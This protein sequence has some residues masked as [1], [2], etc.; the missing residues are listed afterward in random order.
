M[1]A[2]LGRVLA[3]GLPIALLAGPLAAQEPAPVWANLNSGVYHCPG[4]Q[5]YGRTVRGEF[6]D[7]SIARERGFRP[8]GG[9]PCTPGLPAA[10]S[11]LAGPAPDAPD[12]TPPR[13]ESG[14]VECA[15]TRIT[16]GDTIWCGALGEIRLIGMDTPESDQE[17]YGTAA[18]AALAALAPVATVLQV[19]V[20]ADPRDRYGRLLAY[21]WLDGVMLNWLLV[22]QGWAVSL[23]YEPN[24]RYR[25]AFE[26]AEWRAAA[27]ARGLW[28]VGGLLC[29]PVDHRRGSC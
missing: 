20:G 24:T 8:N 21:A 5:H 7:E 22:R 12:T 1:R 13:P 9:R 27:E 3:F 29:R 6:L 16:D 25:P 15:L 26:A 2:L 11:G 19:E 10:P 23:A 4:T 14:L 28:S 18:T 17:P